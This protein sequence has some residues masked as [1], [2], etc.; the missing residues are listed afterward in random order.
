MSLFW[1]EEMPRPVKVRRVCEEPKYTRFV[2]SGADRTDAVVLSIE[3]Y[4]V[5]RHS[6]IK[7][8][9]IFLVNIYYLFS[10]L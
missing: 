4:E 7:G 1:S 8:L 2:P 10:I 3:E 9:E 6:A 5:I